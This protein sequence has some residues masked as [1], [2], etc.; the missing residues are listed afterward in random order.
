[1]RPDF[2]GLNS[3]RFCATCWHSRLHFFHFG[4]F[5]FNVAFGLVDVF[6]QVVNL[7]TEVLMSFSRERIFACSESISLIFFLPGMV[8]FYGASMVFISSAAFHLF[9]KLSFFCLVFAGVGGWGVQQ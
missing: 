3:G 6:I 8:F 1:M 5:V 7:V 4:A 9:L 2:A